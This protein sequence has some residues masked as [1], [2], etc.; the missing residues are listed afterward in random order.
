MSLTQSRMR[1]L[2]AEASVPPAAMRPRHPF[3]RRAGA[4]LPSRVSSSTPPSTASPSSPLASFSKRARCRTPLVSAPQKGFSYRLCAPRFPCPSL[5]PT[6]FPARRSPSS[7]HLAPSPTLR[8]RARLRA[9]RT[10][11]AKLGSTRRACDAWC[12]QR[13][14]LRVIS[15]RRQHR[16]ACLVLV[17]RWKPP[18]ARLT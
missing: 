4:A 10:A 8:V 9:R 5:A 1:R 18:C 13:C 7:P 6:P 12:F 3:S 14:I 2:C 17:E 16:K 11:A 15:P